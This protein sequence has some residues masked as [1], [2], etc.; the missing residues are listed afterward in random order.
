M[1]ELRH[2]GGPGTSQEQ[3]GHWELHAPHLEKQH[4]LQAQRQNLQQLHQQGSYHY[5]HQHR[6]LSTSSSL[7]LND[8]QHELLLSSSISQP[9][10]PP[11][12]AALHPGDTSLGSGLLE[13][14]VKHH[15]QS[16]QHVPGMLLGHNGQTSH[17][18]QEQMVQQT[19]TQHQP[20]GRPAGV[21]TLQPPAAA[22]ALAPPATCL[23]AVQPESA[24]LSAGELHAALTTAENWLGYGKGSGDTSSENANA[25]LSAFLLDTGSHSQLST[26]EW[27]NMDCLDSYADL[28]WVVHA[29]STQAEFDQRMSGPQQ[30]Q[31][32]GSTTS[33]PQ[34]HA[35]TLPFNNINTELLDSITP[36]QQQQQLKACTQGQLDSSMDDCIDTLYSI[37]SVRSEG[38]PAAVS[39]HPHHL[40]HDCME[41]QAERASSRFGLDTASQAP[42][43]TWG[44]ACAV[45]SMHG[46]G[47]QQWGSLVNHLPHSN[48]PTGRVVQGYASPGSQQH[49]PSSSIHGA[50]LHGQTWQQVCGDTTNCFDTQSG[51]QPEQHRHTH[52]ILSSGHASADTPH[53]G[54]AHT[55]PWSQHGPQ[56]TMQH[57]HTCQAGYPSTIMASGNSL[58]SQLSSDRSAESH[59]AM[60][61]DLHGMVGHHST[62]HM[63]HSS[64]HNHSPQGMS[65]AVVLQGVQQ[66]GYSLQGTSLAA[67]GA[68]AQRLA[69][70]GGRVEYHS[71]HHEFVGET[72]EH[73]PWQ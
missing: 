19:N 25:L 66:S 27:A 60:G 44:N 18:V 7:P 53:C 68:Q 16:S 67:P 50:P 8:T 38:R 6:P 56:P 29:C 58:W 52:A 17:A 28:S 32:R 48:Q 4:H 61:L 51:M 70:R 21:N 65:P 59:G 63:G 13:Q 72:P 12:Q 26:Q 15:W 34:W 3:H 20:Y 9:A 2:V 69:C 40:Q 43:Q 73:M 14:E 10:T 49:G 37:N 45:P 11:R 55:V 39:L 24:S 71:T 23:Q 30:Q 33:W 5:Q 64:C 22:P 35:T 41:K 1:Q 31:Q 36:T 42:P 46:S 57:R 47:Q 54:Q 62:Q